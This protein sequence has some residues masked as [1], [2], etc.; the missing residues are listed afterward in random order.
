MAVVKRVAADQFLFAP[1]FL[2]LFIGLN[3]FLDSFNA[4]ESVQHVKAQWTHTVTMNWV[5]WIPFQALNFKFVPVSYQ[6]LANNFCGV[7]WNGYLSWRLNA[8]KRLNA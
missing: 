6:V 3:S 4:I 8:P 1:A 5:L 7:A 2:A